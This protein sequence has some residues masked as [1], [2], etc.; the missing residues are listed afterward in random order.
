MGPAGKLFNICQ[1]DQSIEQYAREFFGVAQ[2]S[3]MEKT[4]LMIILFWG[5]LAEPF[6]SL[7]PYWVPEESLE[8]YSTSCPFL[9]RPRLIRS[10][11]EPPLMS[12]RAACS[13]RKAP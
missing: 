8:G 2:R 7:M 6:K 12:V 1:G 9:E 4:C 10:V 11:Q 3:M 5:G 13:A